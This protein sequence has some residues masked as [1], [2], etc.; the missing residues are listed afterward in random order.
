MTSA[1]IFDGG[2]CWGRVVAR[3][4]V[5][6]S[7][8]ATICAAIVLPTGAVAQ[9][10]QASPQLDNAPTEASETN[11]EP[12]AAGPPRPLAIVSWHLDDADK[13]GAV[14]IRPEPQ[15]VWRHTFG[16][17]RKSPS[18]ANFDI[19]KLEA[20]VVLL[21]G[22]R[23]LAH[24]RLLFP[25]SQWRVVASRQIVQPMIA[26][27]GGRARW[28]SAP[29]P[30]TTA[31]AIRYQRRVRV[32]GVEHIGEVVAS[33]ADTSD[34]TTA[35]ETPAAVAVR[36]RID[37]RFVW[38]VSADLPAACSVEPGGATACP[39]RDALAQWQTARR[40]SER[41]VIGGPNT[42]HAPSSPAATTMCRG[43]GR[44]SDRSSHAGLLPGLRFVAEFV[45]TLRCPGL[46]GATPRDQ[47][48]NSERWRAHVVACGRR[49]RTMAGL[50]WQTWRIIE[51]R[52]QDQ[53]SRHFAARSSG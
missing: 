52:R 28:G 43:H 49:T 20:D 9:S 29:R 17:E 35:S 4:L 6:V 37:G 5:V 27:A 23:M 33:A 14:D 16:A 26:G 46:V 30:P 42:T 53:R 15:R 31:V 25:A 51:R 22:L 8:F 12:P 36:L 2:R 7:W 24:A 18:R 45:A 38:V 19:A 50:P 41:A 3:R 47:V 21:Q 34:T 10:Q 48:R 11:E 1:R 32:M 13:A 40:P 44:R 39:A